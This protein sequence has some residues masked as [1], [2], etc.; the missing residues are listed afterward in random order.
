[1]WREFGD[2]LTTYLGAHVEELSNP[3]LIARDLERERELTGAEV[4]LYRV[5]G[6]LIAS[7]ARPAVAP[8]SELEAKRLVTG[9][10]R[11]SG[12]AWAVGGAGAA[13][14]SGRGVRAASR[15]RTPGPT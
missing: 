4:S 13:A 7:S 5:D 10:L 2:R 6:T 9:A 12:R 14:R 3:E 1:V 11:S 8:L 15:P